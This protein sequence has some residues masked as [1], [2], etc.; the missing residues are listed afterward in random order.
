MPVK[1]FILDDSFLVRTSGTSDGTQD[2]FCKDGFWFKV[3]RYGGEGLA[4]T[5]AS[6]ILQY[7]GLSDKNNP[8]LEKNA[9]DHLLYQFPT[10]K[11]G[12]Q[13]SFEFVD[14]PYME[15][16]AGLHNLLKVFRVE[17]TRRLNYLD[18]PKASKWGINVGMG[19]YM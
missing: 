11:Y 3:D 16:S 4:E 19:L 7:G 17:V 1:E 15:V 8:F 10:D 13:T 2:K 9:D 12:N 6:I 5:A 14:K 18:H